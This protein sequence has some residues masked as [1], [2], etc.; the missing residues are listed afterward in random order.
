VKIHPVLAGKK[1]GLIFEN[2]QQ[3]Q[4]YH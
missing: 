1:L 4:E 3:E 2:L